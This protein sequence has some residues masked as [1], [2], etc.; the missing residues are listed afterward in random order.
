MDFSHFSHKQL[1]NTFQRYSNHS[2]FKVALQGHLRITEKYN[3]K[4]TKMDQKLVKQ[5]GIF[6][7]FSTFFFKVSLFYV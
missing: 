4:E 7:N 5:K 1:S 2:Q 3:I 6:T